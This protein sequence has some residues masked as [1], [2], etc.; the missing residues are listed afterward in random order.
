MIPE[1]STG[2]QATTSLRKEITDWL[3]RQD[4]ASK[5]DSGTPN[6]AAQTEMGARASSSAE[7]NVSTPARQERGWIRNFLGLSGAS[8]T[9]IAEV[10]D[11]GREGSIDSEEKD[12]GR[13]RGFFG[14]SR[15]RE[16]EKEAD[17]ELTRMIGGC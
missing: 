5:P 9:P 2:P 16:R 14:S 3:K 1:S 8:G 4:F 12:K 17:K 6:A 11:N 15:E 7:E 10:D 13:V